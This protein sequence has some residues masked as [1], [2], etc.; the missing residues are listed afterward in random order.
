MS[1]EISNGRAI[2]NGLAAPFRPSPNVGGALRPEYIVL[3]DTGSGLNDSGSI[4]WLTDRAS[5]VSA[6]VVIGRDGRITQLVPFGVKA[7]HAG[8]SVWRGRPLLNGFSIGIEIINPGRLTKIGE[9]VYK[10]VCTIDTNRD[11]SLLVQHAKTAA[12]GDGYW[13]AYSDAQIRA[14]RELCQA[15][16][17]EYPI[18]EIVTH[19]LISPGR[20]V[21]T[22]PLFPLEQLRQA[23]LGR[24]KPMG[25]VDTSRQD[26]DEAAGGDVDDVAPIGTEDEV[27]SHDDIAA[28]RPVSDESAGGLGQVWK[29]IKSKTQWATTAL[30]GIS[31]TSL[32]TFLQDWR[33]LAVLGAVVVALVALVIFERSRKP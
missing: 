28:S 2:I 29:L 11:R 22:N 21:D 4:A 30:G 31:L 8:Q 18:K 15:I 27:T 13:L 9:G 10:G 3:H 14:V 1:I 6:H 17:Q 23:C 19:W 5:K 16:C 12:H 24:A 7:W 20:K 32:F 25:V 33:V 26:S